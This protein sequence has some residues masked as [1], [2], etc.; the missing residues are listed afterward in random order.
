MACGADRASANS[1][2]FFLDYADGGGL[3]LGA[4]DGVRALFQ[5]HLQSAGLDWAQRAAEEVFPRFG[6]QSGRIAH[7]LYHAESVICAGWAQHD[8]AFAAD[9]GCAVW[10]RNAGERMG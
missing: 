8:A 5:H 3:L 4:F 6:F 7:G 2:Q 10:T 1:A 9:N